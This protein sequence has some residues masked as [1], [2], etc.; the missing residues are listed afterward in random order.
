[1][2]A[3]LQVLIEGVTSRLQH[4]RFT[5]NTQTSTTL[6]IHVPEPYTQNAREVDTNLLHAYM[7]V[8][9]AVQFDSTDTER[10]VCVRLHNWPMTNETMVALRGLPHWA[11][12]LDLTGCTWALR[13]G[14]YRQ[15]AA[16]VP[17]SYARWELQAPPVQATGGAWSSGAAT[18]PSALLESICEGINKRRAARG[19]QR[20]TY[21]CVSGTAQT[22]TQTQGK[23]AAHV[24]QTGAHVVI[25]PYR[26]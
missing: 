4:I 22:Q 12:T 11:G 6:T 7:S 2:C 24:V 1:M 25:T 10:V 21:Q 19:M 17:E 9:K 8:L 23:H 26:G 13:P 18:K 14:V 3:V 5:P 16:C 20:L 15:L